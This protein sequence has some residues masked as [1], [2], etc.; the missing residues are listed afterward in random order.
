MSRRESAPEARKPEKK[1]PAIEA[2]VLSFLLTFSPADVEGRENSSDQEDT[3]ASVSAKMNPDKMAEK[4]ETLAQD[5]YA[6]LK[7]AENPENLSPEIKEKMLEL[8]IQLEKMKTQEDCNESKPAL[9]AL[10]LAFL[11]IFVKEVLFSKKPASKAE[12]SFAP[13]LT[14]EKIK[15]ILEFSREDIKTNLETLAESLKRQCEGLP[16]DNG[17]KIRVDAVANQILSEW[18]DQCPKSNLAR[19]QIILEQLLKETDNLRTGEKNIQERS[20]I[21]STIKRL[22]SALIA[23]YMK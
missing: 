9:I 8:L 15:N 4:A 17:V 23:K 3:R 7:Y 2:L 20:E 16:E 1:S 6:H 21:A 22:C 18:T 11:I 13:F 19:V 14:E 12:Q 5:I 10:A